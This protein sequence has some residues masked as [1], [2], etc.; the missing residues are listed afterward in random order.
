MALVLSV[1]VQHVPMYSSRE[2]IENL[3]VKFSYTHTRNEEY[4]YCERPSLTDERTIFSST[5]MCASWWSNCWPFCHHYP[6]SP[7]DG[8]KPSQFASLWLFLPHCRNYLPLAHREYSS[9]CICLSCPATVLPSSQ[10]WFLHECLP[11][12]FCCLHTEVLWYASPVRTHS[13]TTVN[14]FIR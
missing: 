10:P 5:W 11:F 8:Y 13:A 14:L 7:Y 4:S 9:T 6:H 2:Y 12:Q 3:Y 1:P